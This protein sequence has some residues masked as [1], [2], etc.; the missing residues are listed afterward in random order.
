[1]LSITRSV[2]RFLLETIGIALVLYLAFLLVG[3]PRPFALA[4]VFFGLL[5]AFFVELLLSRRRRHGP[6]VGP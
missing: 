2:S 3:N 4:F 6:T 1:M 5:G